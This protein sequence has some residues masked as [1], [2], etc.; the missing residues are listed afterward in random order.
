MGSTRTPYTCALCWTNWQPLMIVTHSEI[1]YSTQSHLLIVGVESH[2]IWPIIKSQNSSWPNNPVET[3]QAAHTEYVLHATYMHDPCMWFNVYW[4][5]LLWYLACPCLPSRGLQNIHAS[6]IPV[7]QL[8]LTGRTERVLRGGGSWESPRNQF[9][10]LEWCKHDI[11][12]LCVCVIMHLF[13][14]L[15][16]IHTVSFWIHGTV[17]KTYAFTIFLLGVAQYLICCRLPLLHSPCWFAESVSEM[18]GSLE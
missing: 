15:Y 11:L 9:P 8:W 14:A 6:H 12:H 13:S 1:V 3:P 2:L 10:I 7:T 18:T 16:L 4:L 5:P 17:V